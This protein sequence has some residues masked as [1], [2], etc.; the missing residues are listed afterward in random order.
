MGVGVKRRQLLLTTTMLAG[1]LVGYGGRAYGACT[2]V[3]I[4]SK[5]ECSGTETTTQTINFDNAEVVSLASPAF[6]VNTTAGGSVGVSVTGDGALSYTGELRHGSNRDHWH[7]NYRR[8]RRFSSKD[9]NRILSAAAGIAVGV[10]WN[11]ATTKSLVWR[12]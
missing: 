4:T 8:G 10:V 12:Q 5:F 1:A 3:G 9:L 2:Q 6:S 11:Y 7:G